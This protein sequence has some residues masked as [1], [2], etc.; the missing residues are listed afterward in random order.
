[1]SP[2]IIKNAHDKK[3][4]SVKELCEY[5]EEIEFSQIENVT[6]DN[7]I[8]RFTLLTSETKGTVSIEQID[9][10]ENMI[11]VIGNIDFKFIRENESILKGGIQITSAS[12]VP[13][14][15]GQGLGIQAYEILAKRYLLVSDIAQTHEGA[16]FWKYKI[17][18]H[19][20]L[21]VQII[22]T[23]SNQTDFITLDENDKPIVYTCDRADLEPMIWG[24]NSPDDRKHSDI[25]THEYLKNNDIVLIAIYNKSI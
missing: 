25:Q 6:P 16:V 17:S 3:P 11:E 22:K 2:V 9:E 23:D 12:I 4:L 21:E 20:H 1:M 10:L 5:G 19:E 13:D 15:Q 24:L 18:A 7:E 14:Y 8:I